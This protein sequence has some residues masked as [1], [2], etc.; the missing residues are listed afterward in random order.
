MDPRL[1]Y[2]GDKKEAALLTTI[3]R[4]I[5]S[6]LDFN[7]ESFIYIYIY[8]KLS[9]LKSR[10]EIIRRFT[11]LYPSFIRGEWNSP[12]SCLN[13]SKT[14][15]IYWC[16]MPPNPLRTLRPRR[17]RRKSVSIYPRSVPVLV[18]NYVN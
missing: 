15:E 18:C 14:Q 7:L 3:N 12:I 1:V 9:K 8:I 13:D 2:I 4:R 5:I 11:R 17:A 16:S 6:P 10:G